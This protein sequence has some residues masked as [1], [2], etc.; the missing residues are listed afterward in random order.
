[1]GSDMSLAGHLTARPCAMLC[2]DITDKEP[3]P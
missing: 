1:M 2:T 3:V